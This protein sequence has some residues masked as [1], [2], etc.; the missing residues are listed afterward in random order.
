MQAPVIGQVHAMLGA[1]AQLIGRTHL[2]AAVT[3]LAGLVL[4]RI[5]SVYVLG[6]T[7]RSIR[8]S[9]RHLLKTLLPRGLVNAVLAIQVAARVNGME[10]LPAM[11]FTLI[12]ATNFLVMLADWRFRLSTT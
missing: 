12:W 4:A 7:M 1:S 3:L 5:G 2:V 10:F 8:R 9:E 6:L 11:E